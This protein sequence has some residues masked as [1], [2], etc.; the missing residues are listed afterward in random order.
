MIIRS[1]KGR[2]RKLFFIVLLVLVCIC[3]VKLTKRLFH[4][5]DEKW[6][7][8][9]S[10]S[11]I[12]EITYNGQQYRYNQNLINVLYLGIDNNDVI[13]DDMMPGEA[14]QTDCILLISLNKETKEAKILQIPRDTMTEIDI[15]NRG[16]EVFKTIQA[17]IAT[18]YAYCTGGANS[19]WAATKTISEMLY[20]LPIDAY[21]AMDMASI[22][23]VNDAV[24]GVTLTIPKDYTIIRPEFEEGATLTLSG[25][26]AYDYVHWRDT[27]ASFSNNDR[28]E[29]QTQYIPAMID[30]VRGNAE[31]EGNY[32]ETLYK[33]VEEYMITDLQEDEINRMG[34]FELSISDIQR[35]PGEGKKGERFEEFYLDDEKLQKMLIETF[36]ILKK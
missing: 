15:Y 1:N 19:C 27:Y 13:R 10:Q 7:D 28:M 24:G 29:R 31:L 4:E 26:Q 2:K 18:Q 3:G 5:N 25:Q 12:G 32:Y 11:S 21:L 33:L 23:M 17:Q 20:D 14:G 30:T 16:G 34:E 35:L 36:Y 22:P 6:D 8:T 9:L